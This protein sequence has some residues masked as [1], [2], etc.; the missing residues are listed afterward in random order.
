M[1]TELTHLVVYAR[2]Y[3]GDNAPGADDYEKKQRQRHARRGHGLPSYRREYLAPRRWE[4]DPGERA[5]RIWEWWRGLL[6]ADADDEI[7]SKVPSFLKV[8]MLVALVQV[9][10]AA[11]E[12]VF[13]LLKRVRD[14]CGDSLVES[15]LE[16]RLF[17]L[18]AAGTGLLV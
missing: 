1:K 17:L 18:S 15:T 3:N 11:A 12:R 6:K 13:S 4:D 10:S 2:Q 14:A 7:R 5:R 16:L 9:S 8:V